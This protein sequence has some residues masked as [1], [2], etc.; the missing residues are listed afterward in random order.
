MPLPDRF[1][2]DEIHFPLNACQ[3]RPY[4]RWDN[5]RR[6]RIV[7]RWRRGVHLSADN[8]SGDRHGG[9]YHDTGRA[10]CYQSGLFQGGTSSDL[11]GFGR[12]GWIAGE[13]AAHEDSHGALCITRTNWTAGPLFPAKARKR[14]SHPSMHREGMTHQEHRGK[15]PAELQCGILILTGRHCQGGSC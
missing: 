11:R 10:Q 8:V 15:R 12:G 6:I 5:P 3:F 9:R 1:V 13:K 4:I 7:S 2:F 14:M